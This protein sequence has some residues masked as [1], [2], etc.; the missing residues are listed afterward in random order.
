MKRSLVFAA[1]SIPIAACA[2]SA[3]SDPRVAPTAPAPV[4]LPSSEEGV[5]VP[6]SRDDPSWGSRDA[7]VTVVLFGDLECPYTGK[8]L[9]TVLA[10]EEKYGAKD[11]RVVWK[12]DPLSFHPHARPASVAAQSVFAVAGAD[13]FWKV[14]REALLHQ[15]DLSP[16]SFESWVSGAGV[17][18]GQFRSALATPA[19]TAKVDAGLALADKLRVD[20][21]PTFFINCTQITGAQPLET[22][23]AA[24]DSE[25]V[26]AKARLAA[27]LAADAV[28]AELTN[29]NWKEPKEEA[30]E[31]DEKEDTTTVWSVPLGAAPARGRPDALVTIV[32]FSDFECPYCKRAE[33]V[34]HE[35]THAYGDKVRVVW[36]DE[37]LSFHRHALPAA[38]L[39]REARAEKGDPAF[40]AAHDA[41]FEKSPALGDDD[42]VALGHALGLDTARVRRALDKKEH[43]GSIQEDLDLAEDVAA[44][45][46]PHFFIN[47]RR[48]V[49][50]QPFAAFK[51]IIDEEVLHAERLVAAGTA[52]RDLYA[53]MMKSAVVPYTNDV[54]VVADRATAPYR[55]P[56]TAPVVIEE[57]ADFQCP[58]CARA[59]KTLSEVV[60]K[61]GARVKVVWRNYPL[62]FHRHAT[63]AAEAA[64][65]AQRQK[66]NAG[67]WAMHDRLFAHQGDHDGDGSGIDRPALD[68]YAGEL[69]L[70]LA[71]FDQELDKHSH[72]A[73][74]DADMRAADDA[75]VE[76]TPAFS[77]G[78]YFISGAQPLRVFSRLVEHVLANGPARPK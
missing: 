39:A 52:K 54:R 57:F 31:P 49:G 63:L 29:A 58:Y 18:L 28:Y 46:T 23:A 12:D 2:G 20:G 9:P 53:T 4:A 65:E 11:L 71:V 43:Q 8:A 44:E 6:I 73:E 36:K 74:L 37:P 32:E 70:D 10:L 62:P 77:V 15:R 51:A 25:M 41:I 1:L 67:F 60:A 48:L 24:V 14:W 55:G 27:G 47:G 33:A 59:D 78:G 35:V 56:S 38:E 64:A 68:R 76:G 61:Y 34:L 66:G 26:K 75:H 7:K 50:A 69:G 17:D 21:T 13:A 45:G 3:P 19:P 72:K 42:L 16:E 30:P 5:K 22:L 40:W